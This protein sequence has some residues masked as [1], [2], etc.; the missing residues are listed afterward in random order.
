[1]PSKVA[2]ADGSAA[3]ALSDAETRYIGRNPASKAQHEIAVNSLPGGNTRTLLHT[4]PFPL[5]VK[6]GEGTVVWDVDGH[7]YTDFVGE[8]TAGI[9]GHSHPGRLLPNC[10]VYGMTLYGGIPCEMALYGT[11][12]SGIISS[13]IISNRIILLGRN[14]LSV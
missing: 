9:Y 4:N 12:S 6:K 1:M 2:G 10:I 11:F 14:H 13:E 3:M 7:R 8:L 5:V